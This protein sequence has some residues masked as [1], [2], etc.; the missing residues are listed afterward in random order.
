[1][2]GREKFVALALGVGVA[3][4][5]LL[6]AVGVVSMPLRIAVFSGAFAVPAFVAAW[7]SPGAG[8]KWG[9]LLCL[10]FL[11]LMLLSLA[12]AGYLE[13]FVRHDLPIVVAVVGG[14]VGA[15]FVGAKVSPKAGTRVDG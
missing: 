13:V 6:W 4:A 7:F 14:A 5:T 3:I 10:P 2:S 1:M 12:F 8:W 9:G 11:A 15:A